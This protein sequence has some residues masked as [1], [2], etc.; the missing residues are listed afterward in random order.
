MGIGQVGSEAGDR[1]PEFRLHQLGFTVAVVPL[2]IP[3]GGVAAPVQFQVQFIPP[4][5][6]GPGATD[7]R[8]IGIVLMGSRLLT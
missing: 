5:R 6:Q 8:G 2:L 3:M 1:R 4:H 7:S